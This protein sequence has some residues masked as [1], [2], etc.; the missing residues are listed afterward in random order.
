[1]EE[2]SLP[3]MFSHIFKEEQ[4]CLKGQRHKKAVAST[5]HTHLGTDKNKDNVQHLKQ[6]FETHKR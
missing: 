3:Y 6:N 4:E 5:K 1:M 2:N